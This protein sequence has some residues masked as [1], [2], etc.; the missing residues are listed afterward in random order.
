V[1]TL[2]IPGGILALLQGGQISPAML[3]TAALRGG[4]G[5][6]A[7]GAAISAVRPPEAPTLA[8]NAQAQ[9]APVQAPPIDAGQPDMAEAIGNSGPMPAEQPRHRGIFGSLGDTLHDPQF[10]AEALRFAAGAMSPGGGG[11]GGGLSRGILAAT[12]FAD[13]RGKQKLAEQHYGREQDREDRRATQDDQRISNQDRQFD[14]SDRT[15]R[16]GVDTNAGVAKR[17]QDVTERA[18]IRG[19]QTD[20][21]GQDISASTSRYSADSSANASRYSADKGY[22]ASQGDNAA[23]VAAATI[24][25]GGKG[26]LA[27][28]KAVDGLLQ[29]LPGMLGT[30]DAAGVDKALQSSPDLQARLVD[31]YTQAWGDGS[32]NAME[33][34]AQAV[35]GVLGDGASYTNDNNGWYLP[36]GKR[37]IKTGQPAPEPQSYG[38][39]SANPGSFNTTPPPPKK[40]DRVDG[41]TFNGGDPADPRSWT[42]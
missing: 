15:N 10:R 5:P 41:Y 28:D 20:R 2:P 11:F 42:K 7:P 37:E 27:P 12:N 34:A 38:S 40:G 32:G 13:E 31:A 6:Q 19:N 9:P 22:A 33:R 21:R 24:A 36:F 29:V 8:T 18:S 39:H 1:S 35:K 25:A 4:D 3:A 26:R 14:Q 30:N 23:T 17:G 16:Y